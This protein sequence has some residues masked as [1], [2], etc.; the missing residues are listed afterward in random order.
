LVV[1][2]V[3]GLAFGGR[4][5]SLAAL[6]IR[7]PL[8]AFAGLILEFVCIRMNVQGAF[9]GVFS[10]WVIG[11]LMVAGF[12]LVNVRLPGLPIITAGL[13]LNVLVMAANG[14]YMPTTAQALIE[15]GRG[16]KI[17]VN[18]MGRPMPNSKDVP[19]PPGEAPLWFLSDI[20]VSPPLGFRFVYSAGDILLA[21]GGFYFAFRSTNPNLPALSLPTVRNARSPKSEEPD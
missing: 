21:L 11:A 5:G 17:E 20:F 6:P 7:W 15:A 13:A 3:C 8:L 14:G 16:D 2:L 10:P 4:L 19:L 9:L 1:G 12:A 18:G